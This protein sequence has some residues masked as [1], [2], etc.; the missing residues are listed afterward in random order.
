MSEKTE[1]RVRLAIIDLNNGVPNQG[2]RGIENIV[3]AYPAG[4]ESE[5]DVQIF[6]LRKKGEIPGIGHDIYIASGGPG[7]PFDGE[8]QPW[9]AA[10]FG[11]IDQVLQFN[12]GHGPKKSMF[13][14]CYAF[15]LACRKFETGT[16][17]R[18]R[19]NAFGVSPVCMTSSGRSE[20]CFAGLPDPFY[21]IDSRDWQVLGARIADLESRGMQVLAIE[22]SRPHI[23]LERCAMA[24]RFTPELLGTQFH[25][26]A[27]P[28]SV[29]LHLQQEPRRSAIAAARGQEK[30]NDMLHRLDDPGG[31]CLTQQTILPRF[32]DRALAAL[33]TQP[34]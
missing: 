15:Q 27:D 34:A 6:D 1:K 16:L 33:H 18:R 21:A 22:K 23:D 19:S 30:Y 26:E 3:R 20:P 12:A 25:P 29:K 10:F 7:S 14:I 2:L 4:G 32:L 5:L 31:I 9:Q 28:S 8:D 11:L 17:S 24:I 13:F